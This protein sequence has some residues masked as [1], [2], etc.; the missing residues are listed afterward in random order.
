MAATLLQ[1]FAQFVQPKEDG[2][3]EFNIEALMAAANASK[4][5]APRTRTRLPVADED[6][7]CARVWSS[8]KGCRCGNKKKDGCG[9]Y[10]KKHHLQSQVNEGKMFQFDAETGK[11]IGL[12]WGRYDQLNEDGSIP[13]T[14]EN[15]NGDTVIVCQW[16][17]DA[18]KAAVAAARKN[19]VQFHSLSGEAKTKAKRA[20]KTSERK[21]PAKRTKNAYMFYLDSVRSLI[22]VELEAE[23]KDEPVRVTHIARE[24]GKRWKQMDADAK[25]PFELL[26]KQAKTASVA[27]VEKVE[28][29]ATVDQ[30]LADL[31]GDAI[32]VAE[33]AQDEINV[34]IH[35]LA[36]GT[37]CLLSEDGTV[38]SSE[39]QAP[40]GKLNVETNSLV[41]E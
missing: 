6:R 17:N 37:E 11:H 4:E 36:D 26:A 2:Q 15:S 8:G 13:F 30:L 3:L 29:E 19:G 24:A 34:E 5:K 33:E 27:A 12:F 28:P 35:T 18:N 21:V 32:E 7:C 20:A 14:T 40:I 38:Y 9:D 1:Q 10:C 39:T 25:A 22:R 41:A 23:Q 16:K 31:N